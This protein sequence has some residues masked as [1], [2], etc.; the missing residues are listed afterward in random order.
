M[1]TIVGLLVVFGAVLGGY[2][3]AGGP[4]GV[5]DP[6]PLEESLHPLLA[7]A[8]ELTAESHVVL[9]ARRQV[10]EHRI[11]LGGEGH[12]VRRPRG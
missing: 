2:A 9:K 8:A 12:Q 6:E 11:D 1:T 3:M 7:A 4:F 10:T 5:E